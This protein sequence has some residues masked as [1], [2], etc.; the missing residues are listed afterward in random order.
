AAPRRRSVRGKAALSANGGCSGTRP[1]TVM[2]ARVVGQGLH[3]RDRTAGSV[4]VPARNLAAG[5][6]APAMTAHAIMQWTRPCAIS[7]RWLTW[8]RPQRLDPA[9]RTLW[10]SPGTL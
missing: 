10:R 4:T 8:H 1:R 2:P 9:A 5:Q 6:G 7:R 3:G